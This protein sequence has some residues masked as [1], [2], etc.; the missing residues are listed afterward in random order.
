MNAPL[1]TPPGHSGDVVHLVASYA[2]AA[3]AAES[4]NVTTSIVSDVA[5][6]SVRMKFPLGQRCAIS[7]KIWSARSR[8]EGTDDLSL[9]RANVTGALKWS[10]MGMTA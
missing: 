9:A 10:N 5:R 2:L 4:K 3:G 8:P 6:L 1:P 7:E